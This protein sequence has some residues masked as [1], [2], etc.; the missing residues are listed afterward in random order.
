MGRPRL[1]PPRYAERQAPTCL[2]L[3]DA[4]IRHGLCNL[5]HQQWKRAYPGITPLFGSPM[6]G[7]SRTVLAKTCATCG[8]LLPGDQFRRNLADCRGCENRK[9]RERDVSSTPPE[10]RHLN[11]RRPLLAGTCFDCG[12][13]KQGADFGAYG[14][15]SARVCS[16]CRRQTVRSD[17]E[18]KQAESLDR[19]GRR[20]YQW[21][22]PELEMLL[23]EDLTNAQLAEAL[24]RTYAA[25][26]QMKTQVR[27]D[28]RKAWMAGASRR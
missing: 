21:T 10:S 16:D 5:H 17:G 25:V 1:H 12:E 20:Y 19:A 7:G 26:T 8:C 13:F 11:H 28:P 9:T 15:A 23:R 22:G 27:R 2:C 14:Y 24:G 4:A 18:R 3:T 6:P